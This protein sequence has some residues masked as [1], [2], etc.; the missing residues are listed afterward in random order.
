MDEN[1]DLRI[2]VGSYSMFKVCNIR[3]LKLFKL[4]VLKFN[5]GTCLEE[6]ILDRAP[7]FFTSSYLCYHLAL[8]GITCLH[9]RKSDTIEA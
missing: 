8:D 4:I 6:L 2:K 5:I 3:L 7:S 1:D 9:A